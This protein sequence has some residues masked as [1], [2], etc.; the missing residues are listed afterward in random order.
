A[1]YKSF[2]QTSYQAIKTHR[3]LLTP[4]PSHTFAFFPSTPLFV[5]STSSEADLATSRTISGT[6]M[7]DV[8]RIRTAVRSLSGGS[9]GGSG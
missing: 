3:Q 5:V 6:P 8:D 2:A 1:Q 7:G 4:F 9:G